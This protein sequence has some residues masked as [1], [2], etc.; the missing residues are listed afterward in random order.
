M[1]SFCSTTDDVLT[2]SNEVSGL[3][4]KKLEPNDDGAWAKELLVK[5]A[6]KLDTKS[7]HLPS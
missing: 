7:I 1:A 2:V 6:K 4:A 3:I 5:A